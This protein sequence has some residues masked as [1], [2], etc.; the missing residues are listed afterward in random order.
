MRQSPE[1]SLIRPYH[2]GAVEMKYRVSGEEQLKE[3]EEEEVEK[4]N[5]PF[6]STLSGI[7]FDYFPC[8]LKKKMLPRHLLMSNN[9]HRQNV[10]V[11]G[12]S[13]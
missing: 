9:I 4:S 2:T 8:R 7:I 11:T 5:S 13:L 3:E 6:R 12:G 1:N 10:R